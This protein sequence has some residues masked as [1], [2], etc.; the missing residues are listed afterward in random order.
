MNY[1]FFECD[2]LNSLDLSMFD[3]SSLTEMD[4]M[5]AYSKWLISL[6]L[7]NFNT[8]NV[9]TMKNVF[10]GCKSLDFLD[11]SNFD[12]SEV[13]Y[14]D[15]MF[16]GCENLKSLDLSNFH[17]PKLKYINQTFTNC[18]SL[19]LLDISNF[20]INQTVNMESLFTGCCS[21]SSLIIN[22][23]NLDYIQ[24]LKNMFNTCNDLDFI[25]FQI[26]IDRNESDR[27]TNLLANNTF[28]NIIIC[29][30]KDNM[31]KSIVNIIYLFKCTDEYCKQN[32]KNNICSSNILNDSSELNISEHII[33]TGDCSGIDFFNNR[34]RPENMTN[35]I[36]STF[37]VDIL[38]DIENGKFKEIFNE[39]IT[40]DSYIIKEE[41]NATYII[42]T[43]SSQYL[44]NHSTVGLQ[45]CESKL[46]DVYS[47]DKNEPLVLLK[48]EY[49]IQQIKVPIIEYQLFSKNGTKL[50]LM[51][52]DS[53]PQIVQIPVNISEQEFI[54][55]PNSDFYQDKCYPYTSEYDTDL[56]NYDRKKNYNNKLLA[57]C[58]KNCEYN[59][60]NEETKM[61]ECI[62]QIKTE[63]PILA[64]DQD[65]NIY[66]LMD[67][68]VD[69]I[70][71]WNLFLFTC[72][73]RTF[74]SG[75]LKKNSASYIIIIVVT[76]VIVSA[77]FFGIKGYIKYN[78]KITNMFD[79]KAS[80]YTDTQID[81]T[82]N[83]DTILENPNV[84]QNYQNGLAIIPRSSYNINNNTNFDNSNIIKYTNNNNN[85][86]NSNIKIKNPELLNDFEMNNLEYEDALE[87]DKRTFCETYGS[88]MKTKELIYFTFFL[89]DD[90]NSKIIKICLFLF[91]LC[92]DYAVN[93]LFFNDK[94]MHKIYI[95]RGDYNFVYQLTQIT[96]SFLISL[97]ITL[98]V[99]YFLISEKDIAKIIKKPEAKEDQ[100]NELLRK[101]KIKFVIFFIIMIV[102]LLLFWYYLASFCAVY[103]NTQ[104]ALIKD[105]LLSFVIS[106]LVYPLI[107]C[108]ILTAMR[109]F[110][111]KDKNNIRKRLYKISIFV[112]DKFL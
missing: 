89:K 101:S 7:S 14:M 100:L 11:I 79:R 85:Q 21:L 77:I 29:E 107:F 36:V 28:E 47:L 5:F 62:C 42:S 31:M 80:I 94:T 91:S 34:C 99:Q 98:I 65:V 44:T 6:D 20:E 41:N 87:Y 51:Y 103:E 9:Y 93:A 73:K 18:Q 35:I 108:F 60:Y 45:E 74:S 13:I 96:C 78:K 25:N 81:N 112:V 54:H 76:A 72:Y 23:Y 57:L 26:Y 2:S 52:C 69:V 27:F 43:V 24:I 71:H 105:T 22:D 83:A 58:E 67:Q 55:N 56:T 68:F 63:F 109:C 92:L 8:S 104:G 70:K 49:D 88:L 75:G 90:Y 61:V 95:D 30:N 82:N 39:I 15:G 110:S 19:N 53:L 17:T 46:K 111:L 50:D 59:Q 40:N 37:I 84:T 33:P 3:T 66:D 1:M 4:F 106:L 64:D 86:K 12:T 48:T 38:D 10:E 97:A 32:F 16:K 102:F